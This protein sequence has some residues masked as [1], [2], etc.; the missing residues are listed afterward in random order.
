MKKKKLFQRILLSFLLLLICAGAGIGRYLSDYYHAEAEVQ[1]YLQTS[2]EVT[3]QRTGKN[4]VFEPKEYDTGLIFYP[5]GKVQY[6][7]YAPL[8][9]KLAEEK[10]VLCVLVHMP[11]N[12][13]VL[14]K[15]A[16][17]G[18]PE[19][20]P[21]VSNWYLG[22]HSLGG[23][24]AAV[25]AAEHSSAYDGIV[26]LGAYPA[27]DLSDTDLKLL[28]LYGSEDQVLNRESY[29]KN[30]GNWPAA[31]VEYVIEGG[32]HASF[33]AYGAQKGDGEANI[34]REQQWELT[35]EKIGELIG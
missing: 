26:L 10:Q 25:Y 14:R 19:Q 9:F 13:A 8:L 2:E 28:S 17:D 31:S 20:Y 15:N 29:E 24:M 27:K 23:A 22:G 18:I 34:D 3:V 32:N 7:S 35:V 21:K 4:I 30:R 1:E 16:A 5:G 11:G 12:L 33:G 6:E